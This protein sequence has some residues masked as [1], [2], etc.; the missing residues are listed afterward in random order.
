MSHKP[1]IPGPG[2]DFDTLTSF[3]PEGSNG[4]ACVTS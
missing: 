3:G 2:H 1:A 4:S